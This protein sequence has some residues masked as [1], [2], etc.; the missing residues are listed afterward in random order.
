MPRP[1]DTFTDTPPP[2]LTDR[3]VWAGAT[4]LVVLVGALVIVQRAR[5]PAVAPSPLRGWLDAH[6]TLTHE[7]LAALDLSRYPNGV[8]ILLDPLRAQPLSAETRGV[9]E[10][11]PSAQGACVFIGSAETEPRAPPHV[12]RDGDHLT[13]QQR[14]EIEFRDPLESLAAVN[15]TG[16]A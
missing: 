8:A 7:S 16:K 1:N 13:I 15:A 12:L 10:V 6:D 11:H 5:R 3:T 14:L 2:S 9:I 4:L